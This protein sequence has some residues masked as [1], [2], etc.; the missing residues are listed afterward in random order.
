R[1][2]ADLLR[3]YEVAPLAV[4][5]DLNPAYTSTLWA[6]EHTRA[7]APGDDAPAGP[8]VLACLTGLPR[9]L[10]QHH[11][12]HL[13]ACLAEHGG[14]RAL[15]VVWDG[16][17]HGPDG[18]AWGGEFLLGGAADYQR[19]GHLLPFRLPGGEA[20]ARQPR[21]VALA[22][23]W[24]LLGESALERRD[25][26]PL[27]SFSEAELRLLRPMLQSGLGSP[28]TT[29]AGRFLD[30]LSA[31]LGL[32]QR[33]TFEGEAVMAL[34]AIL[35]P[36]EGGAYGVSRIADPAG[37]PDVLDW[38]PLLEEVLWD[39]ARGVPRPAIAARIL[40]G[41]AAAIAGAAARVGEERVALTGA[42]FQNR[43]L[44]ERAAAALRRRGHEVLLH[45]QV[46]PGDGG[47]ALGQLA[48]AAARLRRERS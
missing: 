16:S 12:A 22:L 8:S 4:A 19:V 11:H 23:L 42:C 24:E 36:A 32:R 13:A 26:A 27:G 43:V 35:D 28:L 10:V 34:E 9:I 40:N 1:V 14:G 33:A 17:G 15:G 39:L 25:L 7:R 6:E 38:R 3:L 20:A 44:V 21:R 41:L 2:V 5:H 47:I 45:R 29:S 46:P 18:T 48:V 37:G 30:G 31:L